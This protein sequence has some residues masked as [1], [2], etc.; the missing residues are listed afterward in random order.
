[1]T[2]LSTRSNISDSRIL[3]LVHTREVARQ[4]TKFL[5]ND[6]A[7]KQA[8]HPRVLVGH[9]GYDGMSWF[10]EQSVALDAFRRGADLTD[11]EGGS[12]TLIGCRLLVATSVLEEGLDVAHCDLVVR[13]QGVQ[14]L[15]GFIQSRGRARKQNSQM[16]VLASASEKHHLQRVRQQEGAMKLVVRQHAN[17]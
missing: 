3:V 6:A 14:S 15:I 10:R 16:L 7:I 4:L 12:D 17:F 5:Q 1:M 13:L 9:G 2:E 11:L 8:F